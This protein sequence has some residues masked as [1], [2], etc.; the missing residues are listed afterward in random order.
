MKNN[1]HNSFDAGIRG[2]KGLRMT[3]REKEQMLGRLMGHV[4]ASPA[5]RPAVVPASVT[6]PFSFAGISIFWN[7][8]YS[9]VVV[10]TLVFCVIG[11]SVSYAAEGALPGDLLYAVKVK[12]NEPLVSALAIGTVP[13]AKWEAQKAE[14]RLGEANALASEGKL[15]EKTRVELG[16]EFRKSVS[17]V[18]ESLDMLERA[19]ASSDARDLRASLETSAR[20]EVTVFDTKKWDVFKGRGSDR[21]KGR[22][23]DDKDDGEGKKERNEK[24]ET[25]RRIREDKIPEIMIIMDV[26]VVASTSSFEKRGGGRDDNSRDDSDDN[27]E[28]GDRDESSRGG[29]GFDSRS[30]DDGPRSSADRSSDNARA[31]VESVVESVS[32]VLEGL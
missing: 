14:R 20:K 24:G 8:S 18:S 25:P 15:D 7:A 27:D 2:L 26:P 28:E 32:G 1:R 21:E 23:E 13:R 29:R 31:S 11:T 16:V 30:N 10:A 22:S 9:R 4:E 19:G 17:V 3:A 6:S 5:S 12:V